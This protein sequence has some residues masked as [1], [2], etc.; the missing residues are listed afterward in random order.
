MAIYDNPLYQKLRGLYYQAICTIFEKSGFPVNI[1][2]F[3]L[4]F[5]PRYY[6]FFPRCYEKE[7]FEFIRNNVKPGTVCIDIG[8]HF[9]LYSMVLA[10]YFG[11]KV[12][13][14]EP[15][16]STGQ[17]FCA[18]VKYNSLGDSIHFIP[19][20][21]SAKAGKATFYVQDTEG[22]V[23][24]SLVNYYHSDEHKSAVCVEVVSIDDT[25]RSIEY[26]FLK[27]DAE[28]AEYDVLVGASETIARYR[29]RMILGLHPSAI[30]AR[31]HSLKMIW[32]LLRRLDYRCYHD[33]E[34]I[35]EERFCSQRNLFD[36]LLLP[37]TA[38]P[39]QGL[40]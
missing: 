38:A 5:V 29:P 34:S 16:S 8:A 3:E 40:C 18:N 1:N 33:S 12:Y 24:N 21:V 32:D 10:K 6:R 13:S 26:G 25:F 2:G 39:A 15:T 27:I 30:A 28:G 11:C 22:S 19:K 31:G 4:R 7:S 35:G 14:F 36:V 9:G 37:N 17:V 20:A 23:A